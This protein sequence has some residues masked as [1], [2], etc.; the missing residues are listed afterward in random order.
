MKRGK[1]TEKKLGK[2]QKTDC[3]KLFKQAQRHGW[4][5]LPEIPFL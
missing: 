5:L 2:K 4:R 1:Q 3:L